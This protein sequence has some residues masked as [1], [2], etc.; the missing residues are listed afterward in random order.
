MRDIKILLVIISIL[1]KLKFIIFFIQVD[2]LYLGGWGIKNLLV[3]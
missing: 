1:Y 2:E 3:E